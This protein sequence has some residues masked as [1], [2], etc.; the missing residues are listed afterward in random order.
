MRKKG[1]T[2]G[3]CVL[4]VPCMRIHLWSNVPHIRGQAPGHRLIAIAVFETCVLYI[5]HNL[6]T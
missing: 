5:I 1:A 3:M 4:V 6:V 2:M